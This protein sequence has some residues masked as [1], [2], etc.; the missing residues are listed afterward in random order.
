MVG[1]ALVEYL[2]KK[3]HSLHCLK[4]DLN[5]PPESNQF[6]TTETLPQDVDTPIQAVIHLA[7]ENVANGRWNKK[8]KDR[9]LQSRVEGTRQLV[10]YI[11]GLK[12]KPSLFICASAVGYYG[13]RDDNILHENSSPGKGFLAEVCHKWEEESRRLAKMGIRVVNLRFGMILS[14]HGGALQKMIPPFRARLGG[15][16]GTGGQYISWISIRDVVQIVD[17]IITN[18]QI[19]GPVN[20]VSPIPTTN[21]GLTR[22]LGEVLD[23]PTI[24]KVPT[25]VAQ[26]VFG[27]MAD[28]MLLASTRATPR[29]LLEA[30]YQF[31]DQSLEAVLKYCLKE[32]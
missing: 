11:A 30:G 12:V 22:A 2:F 7:G 8:K 14:P 9:I 10:D 15:I 21:K 26:I 5:S 6:W 16:I 32:G 27:E 23:R 20:M 24:F 3:G 19:D 4:R 29:V 13:S 17:F 31:K 28:E 1:S 25:L 18:E